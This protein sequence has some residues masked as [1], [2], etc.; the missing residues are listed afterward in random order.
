MLSSKARA[1]EG[2]DPSDH[3][4]ARLADGDSESIAFEQTDASFQIA[5]PGSYR[6]DGPAFIYT[7]RQTRLPDAAP[8]RR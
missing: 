7:D 6:L 5:W 1:S 2:L 8:C 3:L 4:A